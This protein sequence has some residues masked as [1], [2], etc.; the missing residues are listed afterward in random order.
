MR[1]RPRASEPPPAQRA[2]HRRS[3][4]G[5]RHD[6]A[7][8]RTGM[9]GVLVGRAREIVMLVRTWPCALDQ[10]AWYPNI[11]FDRFDRSKGRG[12]SILIGWGGMAP[13][14]KQACCCCCCLDARRLREHTQQEQRQRP[15]SLCPRGSGRQLA[16]EAARRRLHEDVDD[17]LL[18][19]AG[20][21]CRP[22][23]LRGVVGG[24]LALIFDSGPPNAIV[25]RR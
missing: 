18:S 2:S 23:R 5:R 3:F 21:A 13:L 4:G 11:S 17:T 15:P 22:R 24:A 19:S 6:A 10:T 20:G 14:P 16:R 9:T 12:P 1:P 7:R 25:D 8:R